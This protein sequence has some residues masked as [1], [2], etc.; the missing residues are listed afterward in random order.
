MDDKRI[1]AGYERNDWASF[2]QVET[3]EA[4]IGIQYAAWKWRTP[5][6]SAGKWAVSIVHNNEIYI[7]LMVRKDRREKIKKI[8]LRL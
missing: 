2:N 6:Q 4:Y 3:R 5:S 8:V 1:R 7:G